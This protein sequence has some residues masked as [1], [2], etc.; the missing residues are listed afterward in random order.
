MVLS[1]M[2]PIFFESN[3]SSDERGTVSFTNDLNLQKAVTVSYTHLTLPTTS[4]V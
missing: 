4:F 3:S 1:S 2:D